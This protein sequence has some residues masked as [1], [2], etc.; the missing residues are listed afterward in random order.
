MTLNA[1]NIPPSCTFV[2]WLHCILFCVLGEFCIHGDQDSRR[3]YGNV[4]GSPYLCLFSSINGW[5][6]CLA[7]DCSNSMAYTL[8][9]FQCI[10]S[11]DTAVC[12]MRISDQIFCCFIAYFSFSFN[13]SSPSATYM[14][15]WIGSALVEIMAC[16]LV[17]AKPL[18]QP[19]LE[20]CYNWSIRNKL[21]WNF[22]QNQYILI[23]GNAFE[24]CHLWPGVHFVQGETS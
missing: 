6:T 12:Y 21:Q 20:Y 7:Q 5:F 1:Q 8:E 16:H 24:N 14:H 9:S 3:Y 23:Q 13:S 2:I 18:S 19:R 22:N 10:N 15:Q 4:W 11:E 17:G